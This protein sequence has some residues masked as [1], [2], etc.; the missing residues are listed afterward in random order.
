MPQLTFAPGETMKSFTVRIVADFVAEPMLAVI[1]TVFALVTAFV[2][3]LTVAELLPATIVTLAGT[4]ASEADEL[5]I[6]I[7]WPSPGCGQPEAAA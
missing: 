4:V 3:I 5:S 1:V 7:T 6:S 2:T